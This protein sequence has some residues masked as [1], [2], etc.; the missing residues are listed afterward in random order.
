VSAFDPFLP[1]ARVVIRVSTVV[2]NKI[3]WA[4]PD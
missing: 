3:V 2:E 4:A 1:L